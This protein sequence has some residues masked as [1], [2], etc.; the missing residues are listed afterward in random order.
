M[1]QS[2]RTYRQ[3]LSR[4]TYSKKGELRQFRAKI[5]AKIGFWTKVAFFQESAHNMPYAS[6]A[7]LS[8]LFGFTSA[9]FPTI[10]EIARIT[11]ALHWGEK[12][13]NLSPLLSAQ[14][15]REEE[16]TTIKIDQ[17][18]NED[19]LKSFEA[20]WRR[21]QVFRDNPRSSNEL[22]LGVLQ[23]YSGKDG[24][25]FSD[26]FDYGYGNGERTKAHALVENVLKQM[27]SALPRRVLSL[28]CG[29]GRAASKHA[30]SLS[31]GDGIV[32]LDIH[33]SNLESAAQAV[34][35]AAPGVIVHT[36]C[37]D[38]NAN[39]LL[40]ILEVNGQS[41][42]FDCIES[43]FALH[44]INDIQNT[45]YA[46]R[47]SLRENGLF[48]WLDNIDRMSTDDIEVMSDLITYI[49]PFHGVEFWRSSSE[50]R[51]ILRD[52]GFAIEEVK[53]LEP[54]VLFIV[55]QSKSGSSGE[56]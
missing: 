56:L 8:V 17:L 54:S 15:L 29:D 46:I 45:I 44:H 20:E 49:P 42:P 7:C 22:P 16:G 34:R 11:C 2:K 47:Q 19:Q 51:Q 12:G 3:R 36:I 40:E 35:L 18:L 32:L 48:V 23:C 4:G 37:A 43:S 25:I 13:L 53:R 5:S 55:A 50:I 6:I 31:L 9:T 1:A 38:L 41:A 10:D 14:L 27:P 33:A 52:A 26:D 21:L 24:V 30:K 39:T 28:G